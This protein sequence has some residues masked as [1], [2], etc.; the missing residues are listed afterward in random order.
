MSNQKLEYKFS[1][2]DF[3][4]SKKATNVQ[5]YGPES[6]GEDGNMISFSDQAAIMTH[7]LKSKNIENRIL[8]EQ[9]SRIA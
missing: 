7:Y 3:L 1:V 8:F 5:L 4:K 2:S 6:I 9:N